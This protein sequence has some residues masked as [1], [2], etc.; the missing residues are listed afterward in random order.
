[1]RRASTGVSPLLSLWLPSPE[2]AV[3]G[4]A[5]RGKSVHQSHRV[6]TLFVVTFVN[7]EGD[8]LAAHDQCLARCDFEQ[9]EQAIGL[10]S[11]PHVSSECCC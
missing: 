4:L 1:M 7:R 10:C 2:V 5:V 6:A 3:E 9:R 8:T 11:Q